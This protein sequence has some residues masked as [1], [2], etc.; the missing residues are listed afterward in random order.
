M[1]VCQARFEFAPNWAGLTRKA[2]FQAGGKRVSVLLDESGVCDIPWEV[3]EQ[4]LVPLE[5]GVYRTR[6][7]TVLPTIWA[8]LGTVLLGSAP[9]E[10]AKPPTPDLWEQEL[11]KKG[12]ALEYDGLNLSLMSGGKPLSTV[13]ITGGDGREGGTADHRALSNRDAE[14]QHP[15][16]SIT[17]LKEALGK[18][19]T[20]GNSLSVSEILKIMEA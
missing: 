10:D 13:R 3:L 9:G 4:P 12:G 17:G 8:N 18:T 20:A 16:D 11:A 5:A 15:I 7:G 2:V 6:D 1:N 19:L 14:G